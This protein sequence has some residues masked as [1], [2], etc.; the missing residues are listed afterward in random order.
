MTG[1]YELYDCRRNQR[2]KWVALPSGEIEQA[3]V[4]DGE[5]PETLGLILEMQCP[6][7]SSHRVEGGFL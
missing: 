7:L 5:D 3:E 4:E 6:V 2:I 1:D